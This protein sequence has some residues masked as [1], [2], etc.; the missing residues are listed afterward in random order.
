MF[1]SD[2]GD[3]S[4]EI[5]R[6][7]VQ[8]ACRFDKEESIDPYRIP[9]NLDYIE[10]Q[11]IRYANSRQQSLKDEAEGQA[12]GRIERDISRLQAFYDYREQAARD[13]MESTEATLRRIRQSLSEGQRQILPVWEANLRRD[14]RIAANLAEERRR[15][16]EEV[17]SHRYPQVSWGLRSLGR[18][19]VVGSK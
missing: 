5:G 3:L 17:E 14:E 9:D 10:S 16:I 1:I 2:E 11:A 8:R 13:K 15:R 12:A 18:I 4:E 7:L 19:E 6:R